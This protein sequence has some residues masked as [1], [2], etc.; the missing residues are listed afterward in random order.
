MIQ[1]FVYLRNQSPPRPRLRSSPLSILAPNSTEFPVCVE[2][3]ISPSHRFHQDPSRF[4]FLRGASLLFVGTSSIV[5]SSSRE[6]N[7]TV[8]RGDIQNVISDQY[9]SSIFLI[10]MFCKLCSGDDSVWHNCVFFFEWFPRVIFVIFLLCEW[11][12]WRLVLDRCSGDVFLWRSCRQMMM[13][14]KLCVC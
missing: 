6:R 4:Y 13:R 9:P 8:E 2:P 1:E 7:P 11:K 3:K 5:F 14:T 12:L 10:I